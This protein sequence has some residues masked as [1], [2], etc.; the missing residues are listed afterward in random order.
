MSEGPNVYAKYFEWSA[1]RVPLVRIVHGP[2]GFSTA[3]R[4]RLASRVPPL[5]NLEL[6]IGEVEAVLVRGR[7]EC[8]LAGAPGGFWG[9]SATCSLPFERSTNLAGNGCRA[10]S[11]FSI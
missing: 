7:C 10:A 4:S 3:A 6:S 5:G 2:I 8:A 11:A 9:S 1:A